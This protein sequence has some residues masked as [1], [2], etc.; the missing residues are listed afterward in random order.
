MDIVYIIQQLRDVNARISVEGE[1]LRIDAGKGAIGPELKALIQAHKDDLV[2]Y[3]RGAGAGA[4]TAIPAAAPAASYP[5]SSAQRRLWVLSQFED[6][7]AAYNMPAVY[8]FNGKPDLTVMDK[9]FLALVERHEILRTVFRTDAAGNVQQ[10]ILTP[11]ALSFGITYKDV[12]DLSPGSP[13]LGTLVRADCQRPFDLYS[14]PLFRAGLYQMAAHQWVFTYT[15]HHIITDGWSMNVLFRELLEAYYAGVQGTAYAPAPL[16]IHYKDY[17][18][19]QQSQLTGSSH[20][21][22]RAYWQQQLAGQ[23][24]VLDLPGSQLRPAVKT[25]NGGYVQRRFSTGLS[26]QVQAL[27]QE[28]G[29]SLFMGLL[30][31]VN[32]LLYRYSGQEDMIIGSPIAGREHIDLDDQIGFYLNMLPLR[33][34]FRGADSYR[35]LLGQVKQLTLDAYTHQ[36]Y[37]FDELVDDLHLQRDMSRSALFDVM[38]ALQNTTSDIP[39]AASGELQIAPYNGDAGTVSKY[40]LNFNFSETAGQVHLR[41]E[42]NSDI[43]EDAFA[44]QLARHLEQLLAVMAADPDLPLRQLDYLSTQEK[45][46]LVEGFNDNRTYYPADKTM[47]DLFEEQVLQTPD[48]TAVIFG[49]TKLSYQELNECANQLANYLRHRYAVAAEDL[50][51]LMLPRSEWM[52]VAILGILKSGGAYVPI[53]PAYPQERI[54]YILTDSRC[55]ALLDEKELAQFKQERLQYSSDNLPGIIQPEQL[56]YV[57]YTSG[58]TGK[59]KGVMIPHKSAAVFFESCIHQFGLR[60]E[61]VY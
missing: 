58:S 35:S 48:H 10:F 5:L 55:K 2:K 23:L 42:Y 21:A 6:G 11:A 49:A 53:D 33:S 57:I 14:G 8:V 61:A 25:Y 38:L 54:D 12:Q 51:G 39:A 32:V 47:I 29:C 4:F 7:N 37:P 17:A 28:E 59:P 46:Q 52:L 31:A 60:K 27:L 16:R 18:V 34:R 20:Q 30:A 1:R 41:L 44:T 3:I 40:D 15:M 19:W 45:Q 50:V 56:A 13:E 9:A 24:P 43:Y 26:K 36:A 22:H